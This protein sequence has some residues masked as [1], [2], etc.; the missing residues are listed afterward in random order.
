MKANIRTNAEQ[1]LN[2][3]Y[4]AVEQTLSFAEWYIANMQNEVEFWAWLFEDGNLESY[5]DLTDEHWISYIEFGKKLF[6]KGTEVKADMVDLTEN[7]ATDDLNG[8]ISIS[9][10]ECAV[11][12]NINAGSPHSITNVCAAFG[13]TKYAYYDNTT[14]F[15]I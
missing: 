4:N 14:Y 12:A 15:F 2:E 10:I 7:M 8:F 11:G 9:E 6:G 5:E 1:I 3:N 13:L